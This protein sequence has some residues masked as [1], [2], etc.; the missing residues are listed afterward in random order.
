MKGETTNITQLCEFG[1]YD[2][3]Y[4]HDNA[5]TYPGDKWVLGW[6]LGPSI[7]VGPALCAKLLKG[8]GQRVYR[9]SYRHLTEDE[10]NNPE[11]VKKRD[12]FDRQ[13]ELKVGPTTKSLDFG[14]EGQT[15]VFQLYEDDD[16]GVIG[17]ATPISFDNY[18]GAEVTLPRGDE[19]V[20]GIVKSRV[21]DH[22]GDPIGV[23]N[24]NPI[25]DTRVYEVE[26]TNGGQVELGTNVIA[27]C[28]YA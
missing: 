24:R 4:F 19:M 20:S 22:E 6:W 18:I 9:L 28:M 15:P 11:E 3:V 25:L 17:H 1:W 23:A 21:K 8:N 13:N 5:V 27:E 12:D 26:F 10:V 14:D 16:D 7:G 2:W